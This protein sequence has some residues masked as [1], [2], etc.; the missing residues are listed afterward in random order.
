MRPLLPGFR[1]D[2]NMDGN[3]PGKRWGAGDA[4]EDVQFLFAGGLFGVLAAVN[5]AVEDSYWT[6]LALV[7]L[8]VAA[9]LYLTYGS[10]VAVAILMIPVVLS[11]LAAECFMYLWRLDLNVNSLPIP[12]A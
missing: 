8:A 12:A 4:H 7:M 6:T 10:L 9:C 5:S 2:M 1:H 11:P 3:E